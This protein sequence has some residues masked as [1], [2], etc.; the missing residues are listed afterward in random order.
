MRRILVV[1]DDLHVGQAISVWLKAHGFR[2]AVARPAS[3]RST[4]QHSI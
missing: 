1:D 2:V 4:M 3:L